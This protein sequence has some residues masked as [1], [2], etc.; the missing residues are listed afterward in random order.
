ME[1]GKKFRESGSLLVM[2]SN[3]IFMYL[4][5]GHGQCLFLIGFLGMQGWAKR[6][7]TRQESRSQL[8]ASCP[9]G[10]HVPAEALFSPSAPDSLPAGPLSGR[11]PFDS[12]WNVL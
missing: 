11:V 10:L 1:A 9:L 12:C 4:G 8:A 7:A 3:V 5:Q 6:S 2:Y